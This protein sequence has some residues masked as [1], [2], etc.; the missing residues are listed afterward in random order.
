MVRRSDGGVLVEAFVVIAIITILVTRFYLHATGYPQIGGGTLHIAHSLFGGAL[1]GIAMFIMLSFN[2]RAARYVSTLIGGIGFGLFL[3][4]VGKFVTKTNDYF[5]AP[6]FAIMY[7]VLVLLLLANHVVEDLREVTATTALVDGSSTATDALAAGIT[8]TDRA[9][10]LSTLKK[11]KASGAHPDAVRGISTAL[12]AA[13]TVKPNPLQRLFAAFDRVED[14]GADVVGF[15]VTL[16]VAILLAAFNVS[17]LVSAIH[18]VTGLHEGGV[19]HYGQ[20]CGSA[21]ASILSILGVIGLIT[22]RGGLWPL[23]F[24][25]TAALVT[26]LLT[27]VFNFVEE[28]L[29]ALINVGVGLIALAV[30]AYRLHVLEGERDVVPD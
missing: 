27:Q 11:A 26:M 6:S 21:V 30:F 13:K 7:V 22:R 19:A 4:E 12:D 16:V 3:D 9:R 1:L 29:G 18:S 8:D 15:K 24:L 2:G 28:Q 23:R 17:G 20:L 5:Y 14:A 25:R 10:V